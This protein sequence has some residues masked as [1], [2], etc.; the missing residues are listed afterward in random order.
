MKPFDP[1]RKNKDRVVPDGIMREIYEAIKTPFKY[2]AA[3]KF[4]DM[5]TDSPSV[6][7]HEGAWYMYFVM[8]SKEMSV[9]GYETH[10]ARSTDLLRWSHVG[11]IF[12]RNDLN[13]WDSRQC[14]GYVA[15]QDIR[16]GGTNELHKI[17]GNYYMSYLG[18]NSDGYE[19]DPLWMGLAKTPDPTDPKR[20]IRFNEPIL[21]PDDPDSRKDEGRTL[22]K[23]YLFE[24]ADCLTGFKY[25]NAYNAKNS[26]G[27]ER[28]FLA[29]SDGA[30]H[31]ERYGDV[32]I[33]DD[34]TDCPDARISGDPQIVKVD[35]VYVMFYFRYD[36]GKPAY[37]T[38]ACSYDLVRWTKWAGTPLVR[39]E[40]EWENVHAHKSWV[41]RHAGVT[42]HYYCAVNSK[43]ERFIAVAT[44][45]N[46]T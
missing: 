4:D 38:F 45:E 44:S 28:I 15:F 24:D 9:S 35:D 23:S 29:V 26:Q 19:P 12:T 16:F 42:Y 36:A 1:N 32:P 11:G 13:H 18:G 34:V 27:R 5:L 31:W 37:N 25:V 6:F 14:A 33:I 39:S 46:M 7:F 17:N 20:F 2:G 8:I 43:K 40:L 3:V 22:Y 21:R 10:L 30:E 41:I